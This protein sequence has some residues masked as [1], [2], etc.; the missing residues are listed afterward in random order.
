MLKNKWPIAIMAFVVGITLASCNKDVPAPVPIE[1]ATPSGSSIGE[2][3]NSNANYSLLKTAV[4]RVGLMPALSDKNTV[5][6]MF[7]PDNAAFGRIGIT[8]DAQIN[9]LPLTTLVPLIQYHVIG[10]TKLAS[11]AIPDTFPNAQMPTLFILP[12]PNTNPLVRMTTFPSR[13]GTAAFVNNIPVTAADIQ[14]ANGVMHNVFVPVFPPTRVLADTLSRDTTFS[15]LMAAIARADA[16]LP[17]GAKFAELLA[18]PELNFTVFAPTNNAFRA[19]YTALGLPPDASSVNLLPIPN[20]IGIVAYHVH[21]KNNTP[22][23]VNS[24]A[25]FTGSR[26]FSVNLPTTPTAINTWLKVVLAPNPAP[27]LTI[28]A[29]PTATVKGAANPTASNITAVD[30]HCVNGVYHVIDQVLR[31]Q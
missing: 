25:P 19:L 24:A 21:I 16:G 17:S 22:P 29:A 10:G 2:L 15:F 7:A 13:R 27:P 28:S 14:V 3:L 11:T 26:A 18:R 5:Y 31:P 20:V 4:T 9:G 8:S 6:T 23:T 12:A 1:Y 30:R